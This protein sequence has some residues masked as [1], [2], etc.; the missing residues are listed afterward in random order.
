MGFQLGEASR[1]QAKARIALTGPSGSGK[2]YTALAIA[3]GLTGGEMGKVALVDTENFSASYYADTFPG[4]LHGNLSDFSVGAYEE[5]VA[6]AI[7]A[8]MDVVILDSIS[9]AWD[10]ILRF[11]DDAIGRNKGN[12]FAAWRD[13]TPMHERIIKLIQRCPIHVICTLRVKTEWI[14]ENGKPKKVGLG[15]KQRE[16]F[17]YEMDMV[18]DLDEA[19]N[20]HITKSRIQSLTDKTYRPA[21]AELGHTIA[22]W[23]A[24]GEPARKT[25]GEMVR[26]VFPDAVQE[27]VEQEPEPVEGPTTP[28]QVKKIEDLT[29]EIQKLPGGEDIAEKVGKS[30]P[31]ESADKADKVIKRLQAKLRE[32]KKAKER[33]KQN[34]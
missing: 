12:K 11:V 15:L 23:L 20:L 8:G 7:E 13:A 21:T 18:C 17:E 29:K 33:A 31:T 6:A 10:E 1:S 3:S 27:P 22:K 25:P 24:E 9:P 28:E 14:V 2:T 26:D 19:H 16:G 5:A 30:N 4:F 32:L 34:A